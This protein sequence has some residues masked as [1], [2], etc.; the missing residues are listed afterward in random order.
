MEGFASAKGF[1][2]MLKRKTAIRDADIKK[3]LTKK[4]SAGPWEFDF[5]DDRNGRGEIGFDLHIHLRDLKAVNVEQFGQTHYSLK[6]A[7]QADRQ[8]RRDRHPY[9]IIEGEGVNQKSSICAATPR[10]G[11]GTGFVSFLV[12]SENELLSQI[13]L[14]EEQIFEHLEAAK[15][16]VDAGIVNLSQQQAKVVGT[17]RWTWKT[18]STA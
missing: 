15:D 5:K 2:E 9:T 12:V 6:I 11:T 4:R 17:P 18:S 10:A 8:Q 1:E 7:V 13:A 16:K 3:E 14:E